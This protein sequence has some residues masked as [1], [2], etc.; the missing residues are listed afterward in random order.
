MAATAFNGSSD[1]SALLNR[2]LDWP[3]GKADK[4]SQNTQ[5]CPISKGLL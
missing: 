2:G 4:L 5:Q 1:S 3:Q